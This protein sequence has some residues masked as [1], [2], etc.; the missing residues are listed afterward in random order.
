MSAK[1]GHMQLMSLDW[2]QLWIMGYVAFAMLMGALMG[3]ERELAGK[4]AGLRTHMLVTGATTL[5]VVLGNMLVQRFEA[6]LGEQVIRSDPM[7]LISAVIT[8]VSFLG[9][10]TIIRHGPSRSIE[11][12]TTAASMLFA[13][14]VGV[15]VALSQL[16]LALGMTFLVLVILRALAPLERWLNQCSLSAHRDE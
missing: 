13:T 5:F 8:G 16:L 10:G 11:G 9:A 4:P 3:L 15:T 2:S 1:D 7:R 12:L 6:D 14:A